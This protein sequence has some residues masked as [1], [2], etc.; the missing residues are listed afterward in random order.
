MKRY[1]KTVA[2]AAA[3]SFVFAAL[4]AT[5]AHEN[6]KA[7]NKITEIKCQIKQKMCE[8]KCKKDATCKTKC[9]EEEKTCTE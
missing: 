5:A 3:I 8:L 9:A 2:F 7:K 1:L 4:P 6:T